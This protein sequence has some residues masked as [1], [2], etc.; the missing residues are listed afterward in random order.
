[1]LLEIETELLN[2]P[3][4]EEVPAPGMSETFPHIYGPIPP[5]AVV[6]AVPLN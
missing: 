2:V 3:V 6:G 5:D 4:V 1:M